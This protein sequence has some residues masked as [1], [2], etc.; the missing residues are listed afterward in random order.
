[1]QWNCGLIVRHVWLRLPATQDFLVIILVT[2]WNCYLL[3]SC[4]GLQFLKAH[5]C[6]SAGVHF[7][8]PASP[9]SHGS[10]KKLFRIN[11]WCL[12]LPLTALIGLINYSGHFFFHKQDNQFF[13]YR[14][15]YQKEKDK[16][17]LGRDWTLLLLTSSP[18]WLLK[19]KSPLVLFGSSWA[20]DM[21]RMYINYILLSYSPNHYDNLK[22]Q[23]LKSLA[24]R[25]TSSYRGHCE[26]AIII[27]DLHPM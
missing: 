17:I 7:C 8:M 5:K 19:N 4:F 16:P 2:T 3:F 18:S 14:I 20:C 11:Y 22:P 9:T 26:S 23:G 27:M 10:L 13:S 15:F 24:I 12:F 1:M 6:N 25:H 21:F